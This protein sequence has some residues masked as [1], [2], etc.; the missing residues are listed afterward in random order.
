[1]KSILSA[2]LVAL[3]FCAAHAQEPA[4]QGSPGLAEAARLNAEAVRL[5]TAGKYAEALPAAARA[6]ELR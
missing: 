6:L 2:V 4:A 3:S 1:M 5:Y